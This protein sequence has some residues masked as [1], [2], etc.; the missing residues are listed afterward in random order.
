MAT[1]Q[2]LSIFLIAIVL[3]ASSCAGALYKV[4]PAVELPPLAE[5]AKSASAGGVTLRVAPPLSDEESQDLFEA[6]LPL[7]GILAVAY[8]VGF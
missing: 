2:S 8:G 7:S 6:N 1:R 4:K 5:N 3:S